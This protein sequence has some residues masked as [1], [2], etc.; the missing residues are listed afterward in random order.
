MPQRHLG[1]NVGINDL[2][3]ALHTKIVPGTWKA[4]PNI[5][6]GLKK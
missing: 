3:E 5:K 2:S 4:E 1:Y 6:Y